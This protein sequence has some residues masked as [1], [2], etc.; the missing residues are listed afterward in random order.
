MRF[1]IILLC[2]LS[3]L[4]LMA[5]HSEIVVCGDTKTLIVKQRAIADTIPEIVWQWD[6]KLAKDLP[7]AYATHF[8]NTDEC[9]PVNKGEQFVLTSSGGGV[10]LINRA[11]QKALFY[12]YV[13]NAHSAELLPGNRMVV[14]GSGTPNSKGNCIELF[15]LAIPEKSIF[16]DTLY[17]AHGVIWD[18]KREILYALGFESLNL[19]QLENWNSEHPKLKKIESIK[20][21]SKGGHELQRYQN[22]DQLFVTNSSNIFI[23][24]KMTKKFTVFA[25]LKSVKMIKSIS[26]LQQGDRILYTKAEESWWTHRVYFLPE[27]NF[28][29]FPDIKVYKSRWVQ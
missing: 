4:Q 20:L 26:Y 5:Q 21:P 12:A 25:P 2:L 15:N 22:N 8:R 23:F 13:P 28:L 27:K 19:Y 10:A 18:D 3:T 1:G 6:A 24:D 14:A 7:P 9:K 17:Q 11:D 16:K 29:S